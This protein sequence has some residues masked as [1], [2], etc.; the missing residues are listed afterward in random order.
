[1]FRTQRYLVTFGES[2][3]QN[4]L[5]LSM[6]SSTCRIL[7]DDSLNVG[8]IAGLVPGLS[9]ALVLII[10]CTACACMNFVR[11]QREKHMAQFVMRGRPPS[12]HHSSGTSSSF[13]HSSGTSNDQVGMLPCGFI[14]VSSNNGQ[15]FKKIVIEE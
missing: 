5:D 12:F 6:I 11:I 7:A 10:A 9:F 14:S 15:L 4:T 8:L 13:H 2:A 3:L 1:M